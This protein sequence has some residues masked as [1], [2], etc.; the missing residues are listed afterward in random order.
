MTFQSRVECLITLNSSLEN[1]AEGGAIEEQRDVGTSIEDLPVHGYLA[2][3]EGLLQTSVSTHDGFGNLSRPGF[4]A[5]GKSEKVQYSPLSLTS[6]PHHTRSVSLSKELSF[7]E[8]P[9]TDPLSIATSC[10][11]SVATIGMCAHAVTMFMREVRNARGD[12]AMILSEL[13]SLETILCFLGDDIA[14]PA[15]NTLSLDLVRHIDLIPKN[16]DGVVVGIEKSLVKSQTS[17]LDRGGH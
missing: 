3:G 5:I 6:L 2:Q 1:P 15:S 12:L 10:V 8:L 16:C 13:H 17:G 9:S 4:G 11:T 7:K 14:K